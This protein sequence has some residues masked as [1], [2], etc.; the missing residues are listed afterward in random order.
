MEQGSDRRQRRLPSEAPDRLEDAKRLELAGDLRSKDVVGDDDQ[1]APNP[2]TC[3]DREHGLGLAGA[4]G[5]NDRRWRIGYA[6]VRQCGVQGPDLRGPQTFPR[7]FWFE[8]ELVSP[9]ASNLQTLFVRHINTERGRLL[10]LR[11][12]PACVAICE[13][14][15]DRFRRCAARCKERRAFNKVGVRLPID[16]QDFRILL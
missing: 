2:A 1:K 5:H 6:P 16:N 9:G 10:W 12:Q 7:R 8:S 13:R 15:L 14:P 3:C 4:R 11:A